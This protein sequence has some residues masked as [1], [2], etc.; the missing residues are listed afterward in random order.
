MLKNLGIKN[1]KILNILFYFSLVSLSIGQFSAIF[2]NGETNIYLFDIVIFLYTLFGVITFNKK[3]YFPKKSFLFILFLTIAF[4]SS[5]LRLNSF[6]LSTYLIGFFYLTRLTLYFLSS[7]ITYNLLKNNNISI[8]K[9]YYS[10]IFSGLFISI[11]GFIQLIVFPDLSLLDASL[12][13]DPHKN[14]LVSV[15]I[16]PNFVGAYLSIIISFL[17]YKYFYLNKFN[18]LDYLYL[19]I[20]TLATLLTFSRSAWLFLSIIIFIYTF[21]KSKLFLLLFVFSLFLIYFAVPRIQTRI[22]GITD[23]SDS[24]H[25]RLISWNNTYKIIKENMYLGIG[26]N[27]F[28]IVQKDNGLIS[29]DTYL[30]HSSSGSDSS[31]LLIFATTGLFGMI[32]FCTFY[33][34]QYLLSNI[35]VKS[36]LIGL[37]FNSMFINSLFFPIIMFVNFFSLFNYS[38]FDKKL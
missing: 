11:I 13:W 37:F 14:R 31:F 29:D 19:F 36:I 21:K 27:N 15:F 25:Y 16:D 2:K 35:L 4:F 17:L 18:K 34:K 3:L 24:A 8:Y 12:N 5:L 32:L 33:L 23:P 26:Y 9:I 28:R 10:F 7:I 30:D 6:S 20:L 1:L 22:S 38:F